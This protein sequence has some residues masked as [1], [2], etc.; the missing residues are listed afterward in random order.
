MVAYLSSYVL[1]PKYGL[2]F[3]RLVD[4]CVPDY[5]AKDEWLEENGVK[6]AL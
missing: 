3:R 2:C 5:E 6:L 4:Q 1:S